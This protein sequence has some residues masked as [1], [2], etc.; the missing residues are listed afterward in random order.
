MLYQI[1][2][3]KAGCVEHIAYLEAKD[4]LTAIIRVEAAYELFP[5][6][7]SG[8]DGYYITVDWSGY[9]FEARQITETTQSLCLPAAMP[10]LATV[11]M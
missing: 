1:T 7:I 10:V 11:S 8:K 9:E 3:S 2:I 5:L 6:Q 4:A